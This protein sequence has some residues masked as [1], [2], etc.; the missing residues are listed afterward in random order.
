MAALLAFFKRP[1]FAVNGFSL[2][3]GLAIVI[4]VLAYFLVLRKR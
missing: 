1:L 3:V 4:L 2:S